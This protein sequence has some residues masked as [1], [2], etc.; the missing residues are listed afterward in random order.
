MARRPKVACKASRRA[1]VTSSSEIVAERDS[2]PSSFPSEGI[3]GM[4]LGE[5]VRE[6]GPALEGVGWSEV[7]DS[8]SSSLTPRCNAWPLSSSVNRREGSQACD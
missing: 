2:F 3:L 6:T 1:K 8:S 5:V 4:G 7:D